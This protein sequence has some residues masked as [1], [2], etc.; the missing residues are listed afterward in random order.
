MLRV[1]APWKGLPVTKTI[2][3]HKHSLITDIKSFITMRLGNKCFQGLK[4]QLRLALAGDSRPSRTMEPWKQPVQKKMTADTLACSLHFNFKQ[5]KLT[6]LIFLVS[7][8]VIWQ[9]YFQ[10]N[11]CLLCLN[12]KKASCLTFCL[13]TCFKLSDWSENGFLDNS[14]QIFPFLNCKMVK[15]KLSSPETYT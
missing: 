5:S 8:D 11:W 12:F 15:L 6:R 4:V 9:A 14:T 10:L 7:I 2:S 3:Y 1:V 13:L